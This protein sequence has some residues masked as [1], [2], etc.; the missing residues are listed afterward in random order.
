VYYM[1]RPKITTLDKSALDGLTTQDFFPGR[2]DKED[3]TT[4][5]ISLIASETQRL[6]KHPRDTPPTKEAYPTLYHELPTLWALIEEGKFRYWNE[7][8]QTMLNKMIELQLNVTSHR[9]T[10]VDAEK[11]AGLVL[12]DRF[13]VPVAGKIPDG[14]S[15]PTPKAMPEKKDKGDGSQNIRG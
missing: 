13:L 7:K 14:S 6:F 12:A 3:N 4:D 5:R 11:Q 15:V 8:E 1:S 2:L 10:D 9:M